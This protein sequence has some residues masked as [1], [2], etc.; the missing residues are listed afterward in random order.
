VKRMDAYPA[1]NFQVGGIVDVIG[2]QQI[3]GRY[4]RPEREE[5]NPISLACCLAARSLKLVSS[6][7][8]VQSLRHSLNLR[9]RQEI[10]AQFGG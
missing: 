1:S 7:M 2:L 8:N 6:R 5:P 9:A 4:D 3:V 10:N